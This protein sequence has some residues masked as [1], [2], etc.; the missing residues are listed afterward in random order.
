VIG[1]RGSMFAMGFLLNP[2]E[3][4][5]QDIKT[6]PSHHLYDRPLA[7]SCADASVAAGA[8]AGPANH[9][10]RA[11]MP[12]IRQTLAALLILP[13]S[14]RMLIIRSEPLG[15]S[16]LQELCPSPRV[17]SGFYAH[18]SQPGTHHWGL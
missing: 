2:I 11:F 8:A 7:T 9:H 5:C 16:H 1:W 6:L 15:M 4:I 10:R 17:G 18:A 3:K 14:R 12:A 13:C